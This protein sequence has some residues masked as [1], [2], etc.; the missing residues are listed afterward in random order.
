MGF[1]PPINTYRYHCKNKFLIWIENT[2]FIYVNIDS[3]IGQDGPRTSLI[4]TREDEVEELIWLVRIN[5]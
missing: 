1:N 5:M 2:I 4:Q 3:T